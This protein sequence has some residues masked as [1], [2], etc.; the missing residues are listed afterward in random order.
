MTM[1]YWELPEETEKLLVGGWL[2][3]GDFARQD[4]EGFV[5][6]VDRKN[7]MIISGGKNIYPR[8]VEEVLYSHPAV[9]ET[10]VIGV[11]DPHW[12]ES[13]KAVVV[14]KPETSATEEELIAFCKTNLA[15]YKKPRIIEFRETLPK[16]PTGKILKRMLRE[17]HWQGRDRKV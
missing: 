5:Y 6:I 4:E 13:V 15:S 3:T 9:L 8:E 10:S 12:G 11:P 16:S 2:H 14:L 7:D 17:E 1:G